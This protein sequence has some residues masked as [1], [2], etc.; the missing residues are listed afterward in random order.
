MRLT[1]QAKGAGMISPNFATMLC[2]IQTDAAMSAETADLLLGVCVSRAFDR[3]SVD[4]QLST[5]DTVILQASGESGVRIEPQ[6]DDE[7]RFGEALDGRC[8]GSRWR[9]C[10]T[11]RAPSG[12]AAWW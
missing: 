9:S 6:S 5:N 11:A 3:V 8:A 10:A 4:G 12:S 7:V 1:A 2:F